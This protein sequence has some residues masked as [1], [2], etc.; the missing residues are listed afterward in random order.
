MYLIIFALIS[1][2]NSI[3]TKL[4]S[5]INSTKNYLL[6]INEDK[7]L[8]QFLNAIDAQFYTNNSNPFCTLIQKNI[9]IY[10]KQLPILQNHENYDQ[11]DNQVYPFDQKQFICMTQI[12]DGII[13]LT[14]DFIINF[15]QF[16]YDAIQSNKNNQFAKKIWTADFKSIIQDSDLIIELAQIVFCTSSNQV[17]IIFPSTAY[18]LGINQVKTKEQNLEV[19]NVGDWVKRSNRGLTKSIDEFIFTCVGEY[20]ID[21]YQQ[22]SESLRFIANLDK[23]NLKLEQFNLKDFTLIKL[24]DFNYKCYFLDL[25]GDVYIIEIQIIKYELKFK[26]LT[27]IYS[28]GQGISIDTKNGI[29]LFVAYQFSHIYYVVEYYISV[30]QSIYLELNSYKTRNQIKCLDATDEFVILQGNNHHKILFRSD[31]YQYQ[32]DNLPVF[33]YLGLRDFEIFSLYNDN[34]ST[35]NGYEIFVGITS[36][37][38]FLVKFNIQPYSIRCLSDQTNLSEIQFY[39]F[40]SNTT[41]FIETDNHVDQ[42]VTQTIF[43][44]TVQLIDSE[45]FEFQIETYQ[46]LIGI[47]FFILF[48]T[49]LYWIHIQKRKIND[50]EKQISSGQH[51]NNQKINNL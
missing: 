27:L 3:S 24:N 31:M 5:N 43:N 41:T 46:I 47:V 32:S 17:L 44:F 37:S 14:T 16:N 9:A 40:I 45:D 6:H 12:Q 34:Q 50:L 42:I 39:Q 30:N 38:L 2:L 13:V 18:L 22:A 1:I 20:G 29:N 8:L 51:R 33:T 23:I 36:T 4:Q 25:N 19:I 21:I 10:I 49:F 7:N 26:L 11:V 35:L 48:S 15:F 28:K